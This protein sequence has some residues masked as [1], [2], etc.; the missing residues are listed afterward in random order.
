ME[1][2]NPALDNDLGGS[3]R[4]SGQRV[5]LSGAFGTGTNPTPGRVNSVAA[6]N[7]A[8]HLR[9]VEHSPKQPA[10]GET[11]V[12]TAK[13][14]DPDG[15]GSVSLSYQVVL[16][17][18]FIPAVL[19]LSYST[20]L[21]DPNRELPVNPDYTNAA[22]WRATNMLDNGTWPD[23]VAGDGI[24]SAA[25]PAQAA[26]RTLVRYR[27]TAADAAGASATVPYPDDPRRN[28]ACFVYNGVPPYVATERSVRPE[29]AGYVYGTN[30]MTRLPVY[31]LITRSNDYWVCLGYDTQY[32][33]P[34]ANLD[35]RSKF[36]WPGTF[37]Y[38]GEV[39]DHVL[40]RLRQR[41]DRYGPPNKR[42]YRIRFPRGHYLQARDAYGELYPTEWRT[43]D[44]GKTLDN[45]DV[46]NFGLTEQL[47]YKL[48]NLFGASAP[49][50][51]TFHLRVVRGADEVPAV[52][53]QY[54]G[55]FQGL[56][57]AYEDY[58]SR[59]LDSHGLAD[60]NLYKMKNGEYDG[61][62]LK[63]H[64]GRFSVT[65]DEDFQNIRLNC[66]PT[67]SDQW[68][69]NHVNLEHWY[70]YH[71]IC[72]A[73]RHRDFKWEDSHLKNRAWYFEL[74]DGYVNNGEAAGYTNTYGRVWDLPHDAD[75]SWG[76]DWDNGANDYPNYAI[77][78]G[79][80]KPEFKK[81]YRNVCRELYDLVWTR[82]T[83]NTCIDDLAAL[84]GDFADAERDRWNGAPAAAGYQ[85][86][87]ATW[88]MALKV[89]DMK[90]FAFNGWTND[91]VGPSIP[92]GGQAKVLLD[93]SNAEGED[94]LI[95]NTP[96]IAYAGAD[97]SHPVNALSFSCSA[98]SDPQGSGTFGAVAWR[99]G[100]VSDVVDPL[101]DPLKRA[102]RWEYT[103]A[104]TS[105]VIEVATNAVSVPSGVLK[106]GHTY[107]A[108][109][110]LMD[111]TGRWSHWSAPYEFLAG[112]PSNGGE[113]ITH[114]RV[115]EL[116]YDPGGTNGDLEFIELRNAGTNTLDL[117]GVTF[118]AGVTFTFT[119]GTLLSPD[120]YLV[121]TRSPSADNFRAFRNYYGLHADVAVFGPYSGRFDNAGETVTLKTAA[122]G[123]TILSFAYAPGRGWPAAADG[124]GHSLVPLRPD[125]TEQELD[126]GG[127]WRASAFMR[128]SPGRV[129]PEPIRD[130]LINEIVA[131]TD[132]TNAA[133]PEYDSD[134]WIEL[135]NAKTQSVALADWYLSDDVA[136]LKL[137]PIPAS[138][139]VAALGW[140]AF[141]EVSGFHSPITNGFGLSKFGETVYLS[142][143]P[144][145]GL[146]RV[147]DVVMFKGQANGQ[148]L[149]RYPDGA[150]DWFALDPTWSAA[151]GIAGPRVV[152]SEIMYHPAP[153]VSNPEDNTND[154]YIEL[155]NPTASDVLLMGETGPWRLDGPDYEFPSNTTLQA[156]GHLVVVGF[157]PS[158]NVA[159]RNAFL[160]AYGLT[161]GQVHLLGPFS[162]KLSNRGERVGLERPIAPD[163]PGD[164]IGWVIVDEATYFDRI[165]WPETADGTGRPLRRI[166]LAGDG[167]DPAS[168]AAGGVPTPGRAPASLEI[169]TPIAGT[170]LYTPVSA[171]LEA[172]PDA[173]L[174]QRG[175]LYVDFFS[176][177]R[178]LARDTAAPYLTYLDV[179]TTEGRQVLTA[180]ATDASL[181]RHE[182]QP[183]TVT[184]YGPPPPRYTRRAEI[185]ING[186]TGT[187][188]LADFPV[189][190]RLGRHLPGFDYA[191]FSAADGSD[192]RFHD[193]TETLPL[194]FEVEQW[195]TNGSS[196]V[197]VRVPELRTGTRIWATW[198][199][200]DLTTR[201]SYTLDG[202]TWRN[203]F[204]SVFHFQDG[205]ADSSP[206]ATTASNSLSTAASGL[207]AGG[208]DFNGTNAFVDCGLP[209]A[210]FTSSK[211]RLTI[212]L[213][214]MPRA[215]AS[216]TVWGA[217]AAAAT[218]LLFLGTY[219][220]PN[221]PVVSW[222]ATVSGSGTNTFG[223]ATRSAWHMI[224]LVLDGGAASASI[225]GSELKPVGSYNALSVPWV[226]LL[227]CMNA[228]GRSQFFDGVVDE[229]RFVP[230]VR[231][232]DWL[233]AEYQ[234][235]VQTD[236]FASVSI[237]LG[238]AVDDDGDSMPDQWEIETMGD[239]SAE[240]GGP[241]DDL[242]GDGMGNAAEYLA[243]TDPSDPDD[244]FQLRIR[245]ESDGAVVEFSARRGGDS[246]L[247]RQR[248]YAVESAGQPSGGDWSPLA[249]L[250]TV[251]GDNQEVGCTNA[252]GGPLF[253]RGR[254][255]LGE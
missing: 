54:M 188:T 172:I 1:L 200:P 250:D 97:R 197:W 140:L 95:P 195:N 253:F 246:T 235:V 96:T 211:E 152:L 194:S 40:Y 175:V 243:G 125:V 46:M 123:D 90:N 177:G 80:G 114:L 209:A 216:Q 121:V 139:V 169:S 221:R 142:H 52:S 146:D 14:T 50:S 161:N 192:L 233:L 71:N 4:A 66:R 224:S 163:L 133:H 162:G 249:G 45:K 185:T 48:F 25:I 63:R 176:N 75:A 73:V 61:N 212:S 180:V 159:A 27:I 92:A 119:N 245:S 112:A 5:G 189:L 74:F 38:D 69:A 18:Q 67:R 138:N 191:Q 16:P 88:S 202:S 201:P 193:A 39:Y 122:A 2:I 28:F 31:Q 237:S 145:G 158:T 151:N 241:D 174:E 254:V 30:V 21:A 79:T 204:R 236:T 26:N 7:A 225:N 143:L 105:S 219:R 208:R 232:A 72:I 248:Y 33:I 132:Y 252:A 64:Q 103:P 210:W 251:Q 41:N 76:P 113:L 220:A 70:R 164:P 82:E 165:P 183:V 55:D 231:S 99:I 101:F 110:R 104:W 11:I 35:A 22:N 84:N 229:L 255:W 6:T 15:V 102:R 20:L 167:N 206:N 12:V 43:L 128:G 111:N 58:D 156:G 42:S 9:Q 49:R 68:L 218:N 47:N 3:W 173:F 93:R 85:T 155:H 196:L 214:V 116:M 181:D 51:H 126:Y 32:Q 56:Y 217:G 106:V 205:L 19:P 109:V 57:W 198:G 190:V 157:D 234:T 168:W 147:A 134:D 179:L 108:R 10:T 170:V 244:R 118:T 120:R 227:G 36:N 124:A 178:L 182:S 13:V 24:Y 98:F 94:A 213:W 222:S 78:G 65:S 81:Q 77:F 199:D 242:D 149:G 148:S 91:A 44:V 8:P 154:E 135:F 115:S 215:L 53:G 184:V 153:T 60:G 129:D 207:I 141:D 62:N 230:E 239:V 137:W 130:V 89:Q 34:A 59:Y 160:A 240:G 203:G 186:Y 136:N 131:H 238:Y 107:R 87:Y 150:E 247:G 228:G 29:G 144:G 83:I 17:G 37:V 187:Q 23:A 86:Q 127:N 226:P 100:D 166:N 117:G 171:T 223:S